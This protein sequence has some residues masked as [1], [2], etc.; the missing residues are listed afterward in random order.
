MTATLNLGN[1]LDFNG[2]GIIDP[3]ETLAF[4]GLASAAFRGIQGGI[5]YGGDADQI[6]VIPEPSSAWLLAVA[7]GALARRRRTP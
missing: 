3:N 7:L 5:Q 6:T 4:H 2:N 1:L